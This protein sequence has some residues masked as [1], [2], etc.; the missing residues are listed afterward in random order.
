LD[1]PLPIAGVLQLRKIAV[2]GKK[3]PKHHFPVRLLL[4][5]S[6]SSLFV[7][8]PEKRRSTPKLFGRDEIAY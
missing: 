6:L 3:E 7:I 2:G 5:L 1:L 8:Q 4:L